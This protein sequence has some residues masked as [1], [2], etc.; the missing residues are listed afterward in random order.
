MSLKNSCAVEIAAGYLPNIAL[1]VTRKELKQ[2][3]DAGIKI[4]KGGGGGAEN[5]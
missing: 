5:G 1:I 2:I 3:V 4:L